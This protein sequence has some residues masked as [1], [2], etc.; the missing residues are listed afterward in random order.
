MV[1]MGM[2]LGLPAGNQQLQPT[3]PHIVRKDRAG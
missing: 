1:M 3:S 2:L